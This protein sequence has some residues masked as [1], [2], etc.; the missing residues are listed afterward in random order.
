MAKGKLLEEALTE[1]GLACEINAYFKIIRKLSCVV[2]HDPA[3]MS[4]QRNI[5]TG[6]SRFTWRTFV[7]RGCVFVA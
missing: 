7:T 1:I 6:L 4:G 5:V 2:N 3:A